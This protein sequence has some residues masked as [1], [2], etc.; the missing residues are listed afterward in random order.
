MTFLTEK[1]ALE[2]ASKTLQARGLTYD[3]KEGLTSELLTMEIASHAT[4]VWVVSYVSRPDIFEPHDYFMY[5][6]D[7]TAEL[8]YILGPHGKLREMIS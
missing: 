4:A 8:L 3:E 7:S 6:Q 2:I 1:Q 5:I